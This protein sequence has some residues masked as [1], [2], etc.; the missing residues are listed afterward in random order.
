MAWIL[1]GSREGLRAE[2]RVVLDLDYIINYETK[3]S[4]ADFNSDGKP[5]LAGW[6][7]IAP[8]NTGPA[9]AYILRQK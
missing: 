9:A 1:P 8:F 4:V 6:G 3:V 7:Y 2:N 5:D